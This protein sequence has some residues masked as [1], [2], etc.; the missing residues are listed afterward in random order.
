MPS[1][2]SSNRSSNRPKVAALSSLAAVGTVG[3]LE[4]L[5]ARFQRSRVFA[6]V[7]YPAGEWEPRRHG[8][9]AQDVWFASEDG[10][11]LHGWWIEGKRSR[12]TVLYCH[13]KSG[14]IGERVDVFKYLSRRR[15]DVFA[16]DYRGYGKSDDLTPSE[17][18]FYQDV[19]AAHDFLVDELGV[20]PARMLLFGHSLGGAVAI[21]G[22]HHRPVAGLVVQSS[23]TDLRSVVTHRHPG[24]FLMQLICR[25]QFKSANKVGSLAM[26]KLFLHGTA[27]TTIP[28]RMGEELYARAAG[29]KTWFPVEGADHNDLHRVGGDAYDS[30]LERFFERCVG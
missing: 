30:T 1:Q 15:I 27:D 22:A 26:P 7:R 9:A 16:F 4:L 18:G 13:G 28:V 2:A 25:N 6:P 12:A 21:E 8:L 23:F 3:T 10:A 24:S 11:R 17:K 20:A 5:R 29:P 14:N 19:R